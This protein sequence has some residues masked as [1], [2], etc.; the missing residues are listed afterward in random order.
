MRLDS[1]THLAGFPVGV[2]QA[3]RGRGRRVGS[4]VRLCAFYGGYVIFAVLGTATSLLCLLLAIVLR[5]KGVRRGGQRLIR[6]LFRF[7]L[8]YLERCEVV[9]VDDREVEVLGHAAGAILVANHPSLLDAVVLAAKVPSV[10]C[11]MKSS[12]AAN[13]VLCGQAKLAGYV[14][15]KT[16]SGLI[17]LCAKRVREGS[18]MLIF[19]EGTRSR[20][21]LGPC[22]R[23]FALLSRLTQQPVQTVLIEFNSPF[24]GKDWPLLKVP[25]LPVR[26][27]LRLGRKFSIGAEEDV[28]AFSRK[29]EDYLR[30]QV[31]TND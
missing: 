27:R 31:Q 17:K 28:K 12:L 25:E 2:E 26:C 15:N 18:N 22:K 19:P 30:A 10:C 3:A 11:I 29:V 8:W 5:T 9:L 20:G 13:P 23:G 1:E 4:S 16:G 7:F 14:H 24:L 21:G 6:F